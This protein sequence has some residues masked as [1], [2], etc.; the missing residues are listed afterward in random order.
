MLE[1]LIL[2]CHDSVHSYERR[3][4]QRDHVAEQCWAIKYRIRISN[5]GYDRVI[6]EMGMVGD[7]LK[8]EFEE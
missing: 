8:G 5:L 1:E 6:V 3:S 2:V 7:I 4:K